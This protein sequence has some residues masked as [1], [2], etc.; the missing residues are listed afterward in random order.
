MGLRNPGN[1]PPGSG[2]RSPI[3]SRPGGAAKGEEE[4]RRAG[5][6]ESR[7]GGEQER[8]RAGEQERRRAGEEESRR[9]GEQERR[10]GGELEKETLPFGSRLNGETSVRRGVVGSLR[11][12]RIAWRSGAW[13]SIGG[14]RGP[15]PGYWSMLWRHDGAF[16]AERLLGG[17]AVA[18]ARRG[19]SPSRSGSKT[20]VREGGPPACRGYCHSIRRGPGEVRW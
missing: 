3:V 14:A 2:R 4:S 15:Q 1:P 13:T 17:A 10:G 16:S 11:R 9:T 12:G 8:R 6:E 18:A 7:R 20:P 5:E 19:Q